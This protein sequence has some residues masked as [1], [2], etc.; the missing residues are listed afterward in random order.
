MLYFLVKEFDC[1]WCDIV[2]LN[3]VYNSSKFCLV[4]EVID[5]IIGEELLG[6][7]INNYNK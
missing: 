2:I 1:D 3:V 4:F 6:C 7:K 5:L